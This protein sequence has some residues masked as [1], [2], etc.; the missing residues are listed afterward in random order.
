MAKVNISIPDELLTQLDNF[1]EKNFL[2][3]SGAIT[4]M[5]N[6]FLTAQ[7]M[8]EQMKN[9]SGAIRKASEQVPLTAEEESKLN[10]IELLLNGK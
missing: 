1:A 3:R 7:A 9:L 10:A 6:Q 8:T 5:V 2:S 4:M